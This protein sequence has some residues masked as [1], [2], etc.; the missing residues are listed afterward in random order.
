MNILLVEDDLELARSVSDHFQEHG[1]I[2]R[3]CATASA[4]S[5]ARSSPSS[6]SLFLIPCCTARRLKF[7]QAIA[8]AGGDDTVDLPHHHERNRRS[9]GRTE[10]GGDDYLVKPFAFAEL[11]A[12]VRVLSRRPGNPQEPAIRLSLGS[13]ELDLLKRTVQRFRSADQRRREPHQPAARKGQ[14][15]L[16]IRR[17]SDGSRQRIQ[18]P[19]AE[20][21]S[22]SP[23][24]FSLCRPCSRFLLLIS[25]SWVL[26][27]VV[28]WI[29]NDTQTAALVGA[30]DADINAIKNGY[31]GEG[32]SE[33][34]E[35]VHERLGAGKYSG[36]DLPGGYIL[37]RDAASGEVE[38]NL[39]LEEFKQGQFSVPVPRRQE[40]RSATVLGR[41]VYIADGIYH[42][43]AATTAQIAATR[44]RIL[45][46]LP[47]S[48]GWPS[49]SPGWE[50][51]EF[52]RTDTRR[53]FAASHPAHQQPIERVSTALALAWR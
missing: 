45:K 44:V 48:K 50:E 14:S 51:F 46:A 18:V 28:Y 38:E 43:S 5:R 23:K 19:C 47:G 34:I 4:G 39:Q 7:R 40:H 27:G 9:C 52:Q 21:E 20:L 17:D 49:C 26:V 3:H 25:V 42:S 24:K 13:I 15:W 22:S 37:I 30:I 35:V 8:A 32:L 29:V 1:F 12:R 16:R 33:A 11:L 53:C 41:I 2:I 31:R 6:R 36:A 10:A